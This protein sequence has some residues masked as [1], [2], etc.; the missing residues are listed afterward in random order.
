MVA[1][2][3]IDIAEGKYETGKA[4]GALKQHIDLQGEASVTQ[5]G[6]FLTQNIDSPTAGFSL[7][8]TGT[9]LLNGFTATQAGTIFQAPAFVTALGIAVNTLNSGDNLQDTVGDGTLNLQEVLL[10][11]G[12]NPPFASNVT[13]NGIKTLNISNQA[14]TGALDGVPGGF[15]GNITGLLVENN[16]GSIAPVTLGGT[17]QGLKTLL[18]DININ[19]YGGLPGSD[20]NTVILAA[21]IGDATKTINI[22]FTGGN[23]GT[24]KAGGAQEIAVASDAGVGTKA[25]PSLTYGTWALTI[26]NNA[27][28]QLEPSVTTDGTGAVTLEGGVGGATTLN[29]SG[30]GNIALS[31]ADG[32]GIGDWRLL[33]TLNAGGESGTVFIP[34]ATANRDTNAFAT[35]ANPFWLFGG[36]LGFL[37]FTGTGD[38][39]LTEFDLGSGAN[40]LDVSTA[41]AAQIAALKTVPNAT[42]STT[43]TIVVQN[44]VATTLAADD[45]RQHQGFPDPRHRR[46]HERPR[47]G[48]HHRLGAPAGV[49][50]QHHILHSG[51]WVRLYQQPVNRPG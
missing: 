38:F 18:T 29:L 2:A 1:N 11:I 24:T 45:L 43:N 36:D 49:D 3:L 35:E 15:Q 19:N 50:Q 22:S 27:N 7:S 17:G 21:G 4:L 28:L 23:L 25:A 14:A 41:T 37:D 32:A 5:G 47:G 9:P 40:I 48:W 31:A 26:N 6:I 42:P 51:E 10:T 30:K 8:P 46:S 12:A 20:L 34:G 16:N 33:K 13:M 44:S 39:A